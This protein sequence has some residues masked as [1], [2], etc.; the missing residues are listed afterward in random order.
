MLIDFSFWS[1]GECSLYNSYNFWPVYSFNHSCPG[2]HEAQDVVTVSL[3]LKSEGNILVEQWANIQEL[4]CFAH[5]RHEKHN[6]NGFPQSMKEKAFG[7]SK[8]EEENHSVGE[9]ELSFKNTVCL[10][11][12]TS[13]SYDKYKKHSCCVYLLMQL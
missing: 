2:W 9:F 4:L 6:I 12:L 13:S 3:P 5:F 1:A 11:P 10:I 8:T 7:K